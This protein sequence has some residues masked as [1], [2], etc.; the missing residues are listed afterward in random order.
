MEFIQKVQRHQKRIESDARKKKG[1]KMGDFRLGVKLNPT[2]KLE[3]HV[4][5]HLA[6]GQKDTRIYL[7]M[8]VI[9]CLRAS[10]RR[11]FN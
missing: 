10:L 9:H 8:S 2:E 6:K 3:R 11:T 4:N 1:A 5:A 7:P